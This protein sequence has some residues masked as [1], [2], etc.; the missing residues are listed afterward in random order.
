MAW[1]CTYFLLKR[2]L[3]SNVTLIVIWPE[4]VHTFSYK[5]PL[6]SNATLI[7]WPEYVHTFTHWDLLSLTDGCVCK[8]ALTCTSLC[9][10][11]NIVEFISGLPHQYN[12]QCSLP[13][14]LLLPVCIIQ[15]TQRVCQFPSFRRTWTLLPTGLSLLLM[16]F[17]VRS[18]LHSLANFTGFVG[19]TNV[20]RG[21]MQQYTVP[22]CTWMVCSALVFV[23]TNKQT[24]R[25]YVASRE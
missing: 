6:V 1:I 10:S 25:T 7:L 13:L 20:L 14:P 5:R 2:P 17:S 12:L 22:P 21:Q 24:N 4:Y 3:V 18:N 9:L 8:T 19:K 11:S 15:Q 16:K 23:K